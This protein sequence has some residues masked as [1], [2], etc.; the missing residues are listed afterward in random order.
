MRVARVLSAVA[1][2]LIVLVSLTM[3]S[4]GTIVLVAVDDPD[5]YFTAG[6]V[7]VSTESAALVA[8]DID[9]IL[10]E[11]MPRPGEV[12]L[13]MVRAKIAVESRNGKEVFIGVGPVEA[14]DAYLG[15]VGRAEVE[16]F[17][18]DVV[19]RGIEGA[20]VASPPGG[21]DFWVATTGDGNLVWD[22]DEG[23]W[24]VAVLNAD[25]SPGV[26]VAVTAG[27]RIPFLRAIGVGILVAG[28]IGLIVGVLLTYF[29]VRSD[30]QPPPPAPLPPAE[31]T[32]PSEP[33]PVTA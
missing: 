15:D 5:G 30:R 12:D 16:V 27:V 25:G 2:V 13:D 17:G 31:P 18:H 9:V 22:V 6:P 24:A 26:D 21:Q 1:G 3:A 19:L 4:V 10:D 28:L 14:V 32:E 29:G 23:R 20:A 33:E 8:D 7:H 11:P